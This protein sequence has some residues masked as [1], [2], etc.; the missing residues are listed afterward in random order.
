[1]RKPDRK[2]LS[3]VDRSHEPIF[4][5]M[6]LGRTALRGDYGPRQKFLAEMAA[7]DSLLKDKQAR[8]AG[9]KLAWAR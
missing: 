3:M 6:C 2:W 9:A 4:W 1:M 7:N 5:E 8:P